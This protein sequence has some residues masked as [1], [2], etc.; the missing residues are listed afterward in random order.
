MSSTDGSNLTRLTNNAAADMNPDWSPD[1]QHV[2]FSTTRDGNFE[3]YTMNA[4][5]S[6]LNRVTNNIAADD[7]PAYSPDGTKIAFDSNR[8][9]Q[10]EVYSVRRRR[11]EHQPAHQQRQHRRHAPPGPPTARGSR[12]PRPATA[13]SS[14][15]P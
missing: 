1:G 15:T 4:D 14:C 2:A 8:D 3:I 10:L 13:T 12:S 11:L 9:G 5:G 7:R 6:N